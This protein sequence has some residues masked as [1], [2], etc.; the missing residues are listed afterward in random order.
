MKKANE[1]ID[2]C[3]TTYCE[4]GS[5]EGGY[6]REDV[7]KAIEIAYLEGYI[8]GWGTIDDDSFVEDEKKRLKEL[9]VE[10]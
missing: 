6:E 8:E 10:I 1:Y 4:W 3:A 9:T 2:G 7:E 5:G